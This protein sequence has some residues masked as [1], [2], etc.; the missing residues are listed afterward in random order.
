[1]EV[2]Q[3]A[4][5]LLCAA[6]FVGGAFLGAL[7]DAFAILPVI[8]GKVYSQGLHEK[9]SFVRMPFE[10]SKSG[11]LQKSMLGVAVFL[12]DLF[13]MIIAGVLTV[14]IIYRFNDGQLRVSAPVFLVIGLLVYRLTFR[15]VVLPVSEI[16]GFLVRYIF[17][18]LAFC[19]LLPIR[20]ITFGLVSVRRRVS[21]AIL[22]RR[23]KSYTLAQKENLKLAAELSGCFDLRRKDLSKNGKKK[24]K[25]D[26]SLGDR[27]NASAVCDRNGCQYNEVQS[28]NARGR[29]ARAG[30][31]RA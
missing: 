21:A 25:Y 8:C 26:N 10:F 23:I 9:L 5:A 17:S 12:H 7:Y 1:M 24:I 13:F 30:K 6:A 15:R 2:S 27:G 3:A 16:T 19:F 22:E 29:K 11:R 28:E 18:C 14:L 31:S 4:L 20:A